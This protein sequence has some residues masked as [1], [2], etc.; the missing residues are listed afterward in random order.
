MNGL[1]KLLYGRGLKRGS[2]DLIGRIEAG[3]IRERAILEELDQLKND[4]PPEQDGLDIA[5]KRSINFMVLS[6]LQQLYLT[7]E[8]HDLA[9]LAKEAT[10]K[11][12]G[13]V[14]YGG[15]P[16]CDEI[17]A[18]LDER[19]QA[20]LYAQESP[21]LLKRRAKLIANRAVFAGDDD[22]VPVADS[23]STVFSFGTNDIVRES[24]ANL[25]G[26]NYFSVGEVLSR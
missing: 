15:K 22:A 11:S 3:H 21:E 13:A 23:V 1:L 10:E 8:D 4:T 6:F 17:V 20:A 16:A 25:L 24:E 14:N 7:Y 26:E 9:G 2:D 5:T 19:H 18:H 12:V